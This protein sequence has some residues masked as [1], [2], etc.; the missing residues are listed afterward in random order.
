MAGF[1][2]VQQQAAEPHS[3]LNQREGHA[4]REEVSNARLRVTISS[5]KPVKPQGMQIRLKLLGRRLQ[6]IHSGKQ[7]L[8]RDATALR[9][10]VHE[11]LEILAAVLTGKKNISNRLTLQAGESRPLARFINRIA[12]E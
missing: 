3:I 9:G 11:A 6:D 8:G 4:V 2:R 10:P 5:D 7:I 1:V 12:A